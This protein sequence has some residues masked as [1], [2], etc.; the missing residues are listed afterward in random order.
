MFRF[1]NGDVATDTKVLKVCGIN[2]EPTLDLPN[3]SNIP[4]TI[5]IEG[6]Y[7]MIILIILHY[8][9]KGQ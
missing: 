6:F 1:I 2:M 5:A 7:N 9:P 8:F 3:A 4:N